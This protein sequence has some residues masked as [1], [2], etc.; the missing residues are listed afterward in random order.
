MDIKWIGCNPNNYTP[1]RG[2]YGKVGGIIIHHAATTDL[3][4]IDATFANPSRQASA[5]YGIKDGDIHQYVSESDIAW[6][7]GDW[8]GNEYSVGIEVCNSATG[9]NW[10]VS[11]QSFNTL[12]KLVA[13][14]AK[15]NGLGRIKFGPDGVYPTLSAHRDWSATACP[16]DYLYS[17]MKELEERVNAINYPPAPTVVWESTGTNTLKAKGVGKL[18]S[19]P[20]GKT[21]KEYADGTIIENIVQKTTVDGVK[22]YR[23]EYSKSKGINNGL[24]SRTFERYEK[25]AQVE[26]APAEQAP[27][28]PTP[29]PELPAEEPTT[30]PKEPATPTQEHEDNMDK[31]HQDNK[32]DVIAP[33]EMAGMTTSAR[34]KYLETIEKLDKTV[35]LTTDTAKK[36]GVTIPMSNKV[37]DALKKIV[38]ILPLASAFYLSLSQI[39]GFD[40]ANEV[41]KTIV[42]IVNALN[43][44]LGLAVLKSSKDYHKG[45]V[46]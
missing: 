23:T 45:D 28:E 2:G 9:G 33:K 34:E 46:K 19:L 36:I 4:A 22:Y 7:C 3:S 30:P 1:G 6:H 13:N 37:Y 43:G 14:I 29:K 25:P 24:D 17:K 10:P 41:D 40:F 32:G 38:C 5:H 12:V 26:P 42:L 18:V 31:E 15:R 27:A 35:A 11:E 20:D 21:V 8:Y 39:W 44:V 16:G